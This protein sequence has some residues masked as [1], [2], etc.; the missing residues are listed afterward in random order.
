MEKNDKI[1]TQRLSDIVAQKII[2]YIQ[3]NKLNPG[4]KLPSEKQFTDIFG[5]GRTS[6]REGISRLISIGL[7]NAVQGR[8][9]V[10][11]EISVEKFFNLFIHSG[12]SEFILLESND[13]KEMGE[14]RLMMEIYSCK[15]YLNSENK[16]DISSMADV[17]VKM[18][19]CMYNGDISNFLKA[20]YNFH[21]L[22]VSLSN[23][24]ILSNIYSIIRTPSLRELE[25]V[26][27]EG[28]VPVIQQ[29]HERIYKY[30]LDGDEKVIDE[31]TNHL[32]Y[33]KDNELYLK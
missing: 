13:I 21:K 31:L 1:E 26:L 7:L 23:N 12:L 22:I 27:T 19:E 16:V 8:G 5:T 6:V 3:K 10:I 15:Q 28:N 4:D 33:M 2:E 11:N 17:L 9:I 14:V 30:L 24:S 29:S 25:M 20:D 32:K 18:R